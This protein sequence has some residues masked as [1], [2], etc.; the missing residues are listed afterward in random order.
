MKT[1]GWHPYHRRALALLQA[2]GEKGVTHA[3]MARLAN[4][5]RRTMVQTVYELRHHHGCRIVRRD[6]LVLLKDGS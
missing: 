6:V 3:E 2:A 4:V 5:S 1:K